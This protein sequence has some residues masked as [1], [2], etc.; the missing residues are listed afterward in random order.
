[1]SDAHWEDPRAS[2]A[3]SHAGLR[4]VLDNVRDLQ[5]FLGFLEALRTDREDAD[6]KEALKPAGLDSSWNGW[7]NNSIATF[8]ESAGAWARDHRRGDPGFLTNENPWRAAAR[9]IY[10]GKYYE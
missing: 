2:E 6:R 10:A 8:L 7:E 9:I 1:M 3:Q 5:S 4:P